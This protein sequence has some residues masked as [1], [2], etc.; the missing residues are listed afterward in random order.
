MASYSNDVQTISTPQTEPIRGKD[1]IKNRAGGYGFKLDDWGRLDRFLIL[2]HEGGT[3]YATQRELSVESVDCIDRCLA[4]DTGRTVQTIVDISLSGRAPK[5]DPAIFALA[6]V[7]STG[8]PEARALAMGNL[9]AVCRIGTHLFDFLNHC[10]TLGRG[11]G[12]GFMRQVGAWYDRD[13]EK[14]AM[15]VTKYAQRN[16]WSHRDVLR[17]CHFTSSNHALDN[18]LCYV[19]QKDTWKECVVIGSS[20]VFL[21]A[22]EEAKS[23]GT[24]PK[25]AIELIQDYGLVREHLATQHLNSVDVWE[26]LLEKMPLTAMIRNLGKMTA[27]GLTT[28]L[29]DA[30]GKVCS[31]LGDTEALRG[32]RVHP[33]SLL[34]ALKTYARGAGIRGSLAWTPS[35]QIKDS[36]DD[37]F[38]A[39]FDT[40]EP[41]GQKYLLGVDVSSSMG[42]ATSGNGILTCAEGATAM[43]MLAA[44]TEPQ[45]WV[46]GFADRF[47]DLGITS[48]DSLQ[49][50]LHK[51]HM[52]NFGGT[53]CALPMRYAREH[54]LEVDV[55]CVY[56]DNETWAGSGTTDRWGLHLDRANS[57]GHVCQELDAYRQKTGRAAKLA[58]FGL[59]QTDFT[60][61]DPDDP[62]QMDFV[63]FDANAPTLLANF[64]RS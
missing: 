51:T 27:I 2:G 4:A 37:A 45:T 1:Q 63:G 24:T 34:I 12:K 8:T 5:N 53:D 21:T 25:R 55:F 18:V 43:A 11:W 38:Y 20:D 7:A 40:V 15:Q 32:Q 59:A 17:K 46:F 30:A 10:K 57:S 36:L 61:A 58:V 19:T 3:Y 23:E 41:T 13:P 52:R 6:Y 28:T 29:S 50:A 35:S 44:R 56:T 16:G 60:I 48:R 9:K 33:I 22:V 54:G 42:Q 26:A 49:V 31:A 14:L 47:Q 64:A 62:G 39:S